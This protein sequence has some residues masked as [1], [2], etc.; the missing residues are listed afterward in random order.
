MMSEYTKWI[1]LTGKTVIVTGCAMGIGAAITADLKACGANVSV[2]DLSLPE[3]YEEDD[4]TLYMRLDIRDKEAVEKAVERTIEKFGKIDGLVN[5]AGVTRPRILVDYYGEAPQYEL[6]EKDFNLM[7]SINMM[8]TFLVSQAVT[9]YL[10]R[11][12][13]GVIIN[14][15]SCAGL[16]GSRGHSGYSA[17]KAAI[18]AFTLSW[19]KELGEYNVRVVGIAPDI[20]DPTPANNA[21]KYRAQAYGRGMGLNVDPSSFRGNYKGKIPMGRPGHLS[22]VADLVCYLVSD[23]AGYITGITIP[24]AGGKTKGC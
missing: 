15:S 13:S 1:D 4:Q 19:A 14:M 12:R 3:A 18:H 6:N 23:H 21:E 22:E 7:I 5:D 17:T 20:L 10:Y 8:G 24:V 2:F 9:R 11:Q 16:N